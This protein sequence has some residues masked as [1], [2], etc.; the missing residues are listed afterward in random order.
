MQRLKKPGVCLPGYR[1]CGPGCS[2]PGQP[3]N[4][5][6]ACCKQHDKCYSRFGPTKQCDNIFQNCI[7]SKITFNNK[8]GRNAI[9]IYGFMSLR[10]R[11]R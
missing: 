4:A 11:F 5:V 3:I 9:I 8:M 1:W 7:R 6:D 10:N 2:G